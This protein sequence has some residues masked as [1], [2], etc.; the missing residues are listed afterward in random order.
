M[1]EPTPGPVLTPAP[2]PDLSRDERRYSAPFV[3]LWPP[4]VEWVEPFYDAV[5][6]FHT[7][8]WLLTLDPEASEPLLLAA[9]THD[10]ERHF[11]GGTQPDKAAGAWADEEYN[12]RHSRRSADIVMAWLRRQDAPEELVLAVEQPILEHEFGGSPEGDLI[13]AADSLSFLEVNGRL[14]SSWVLN[15]ETS[16]EKAIEKLD[17]MYERIQVER[18]RELARPLYERAFSGVREDVAAERAASA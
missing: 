1:A 14:V 13:Q 3:R 11:P 12:R 10:M 6:L 2:L 17:W 16:L 4:A 9:L 8:R 5:H 15:G 7:V 18:A